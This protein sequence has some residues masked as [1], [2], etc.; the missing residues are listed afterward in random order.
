MNQTFQLYIGEG[1]I[2]D[3]FQFTGINLTLRRYVCERELRFS[4]D[5][6]NSDVAF[7]CAIL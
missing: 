7:G 4:S 6:K 3:E 2:L 5:I 1:T